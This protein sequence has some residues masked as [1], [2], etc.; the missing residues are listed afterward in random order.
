MT[1]S[2][3][4]HPPI[5][6]SKRPVQSTDQGATPVSLSFDQL[7]NDI[8]AN[9]QES[10]SIDPLPSS[11]KAHPDL[12]NTVTAQMNQ[13]LIRLLLSDSSDEADVH[14]AGLFDRVTLPDR[15]SSKKYPIN[16][17]NDGLAV[18]EDLHSVIKR[19]AEENGVDA[20]LIESVIQTESAFNPN[21][22]SPKGAMGLMQ[23][24]PETAR[25]LSV[26]NPYDP[27]EN[28]RAGTRY[29]KKLLN[30][31]EG[32]VRLAL[33]AYNWGIGNLEKKPEQLP[34]E[35]RQYVEKVLRRYE[36]AKA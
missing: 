10:S 27:E 2:S 12:T 32:N 16:Q 19:A 24:M 36:I 13:H 34:A 15:E 6:G 35:T 25:E 8:T 14:Y 30:R 33:T 21:S 5:S 7:L 31:Y 11:Q 3:I 18:R 22:T 23:L 26:T 20:A 28:I 29:L 4:H 17:N 9:Q 1:I